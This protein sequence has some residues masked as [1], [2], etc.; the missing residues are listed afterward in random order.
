MRNENI[1]NMKQP[2]LGER[3]LSLRKQ[4]GL[5]QE[6]LVAKCNI[7]VRTIQRIEA[8]EV[9]PRSYTLKV[10]LDVLGEQLES[11]VEKE[12]IKPVSDKAIISK[13]WK[14][15]YLPTVS[16]IFLSAFILHFAFSIK[17][18]LIIWMTGSALGW[19]YWDFAVKEWIRL[20]Y[21]EG[22]NKKKI[23]E[24]SKTG[25]LFVDDKTVDKALQE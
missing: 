3:I 17:S 24:I 15:V 11:T 13:G 5:T 25:W 7:N 19:F 22:I 1:Y 10:I 4:Q 23:V 12:T 8:G 9:T 21:R 16:I 18:S 6:E 20:A 2:E 14:M